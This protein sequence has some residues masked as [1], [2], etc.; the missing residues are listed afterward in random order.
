MGRI[1]RTQGDRIDKVPAKK[2]NASVPIIT[3]EFSLQRLVQQ[4]SDGFWIGVTDRSAF[5]LIA[6]KYNQS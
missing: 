4:G 1:G 5:L 2:A 6:F 3:A